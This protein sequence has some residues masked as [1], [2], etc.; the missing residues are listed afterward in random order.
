M[1]K[2]KWKCLNI[3]CGA[4]CIVATK[5]E[6]APIYCPFWSRSYLPTWE[7]QSEFNFDWELE[8]EDE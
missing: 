4:E 7:K 8:E 5:Q 1:N 6:D 2:Y 3:N